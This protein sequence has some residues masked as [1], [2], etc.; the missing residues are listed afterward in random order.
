MKLD[1][2]N[3]RRMG[4]KGGGAKARNKLTLTRVETEFPPLDSYAEVRET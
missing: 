2:D 1:N 3:A 4:A